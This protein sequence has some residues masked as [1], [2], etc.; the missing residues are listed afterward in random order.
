M[1]T[2]G[3]AS[4]VPLS[5]DEVSHILDFCDSLPETN[6]PS[7]LRDLEAGRPTEIDDLNGAVSRTA[8]IVGIDTPIH[9]T[10]AIAISFASSR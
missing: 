3:R 5:Q 4:G 6:K 8:R 9:D 10:A 2:V 7:L 1:I